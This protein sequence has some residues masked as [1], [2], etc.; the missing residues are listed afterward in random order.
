VVTV[1]FVVLVAVPAEVVILTV[2]VV[3][4]EGT[5]TTREV[6]VAVVTV[7]VVPLNLT[8]SSDGVVLNAVP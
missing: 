4:P 6:A 8:V 1:K 2:P 7:V 5:E 3:A